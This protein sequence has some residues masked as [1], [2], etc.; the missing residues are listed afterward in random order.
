MYPILQPFQNQ[1]Q[2]LQNQFVPQPQQNIP[3]INSVNCRASVEN[4]FIPPNGSDVFVDE[5][6]KKFYTKKVDAGGSVIIESFSYTKDEEE[7]PNDYV[8]RSEFETLKKNLGRV[9]EE[10][11][12]KQ[13]SEVAE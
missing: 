2:N 6:N 4:F 7:K 3:T 11:G 10:L 12:I 1:L 9:V 8:T 13:E 5:I